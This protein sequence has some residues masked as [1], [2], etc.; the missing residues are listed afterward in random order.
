MEKGLER[1]SK[2]KGQKDHFFFLIPYFE[3]ISRCTRS[4]KWPTSMKNI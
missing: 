1:K 2:W 4:K 3:W